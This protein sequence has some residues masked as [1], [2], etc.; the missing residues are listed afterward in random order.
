MKSEL[1]KTTLGQLYLADTALTHL[2]EVKVPAKVG[3]HLAKLVALVRQ[4]ITHFSTQRDKLTKELGEERSATADEYRRSGSSK[5]ISIPPD[6]WEEYSQ[7]CEE[8]AAVPVTINWKPFD[9]AQ[10]NGDLLATSDIV[11]LGPLVMM[12]GQDEPPND[13][14]P[15]T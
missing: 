12:T 6:K 7:R 3:Y 10:L 13:E 11:A 14:P 8:L 4:E 5:V 2:S 1:I 9:L 15:N